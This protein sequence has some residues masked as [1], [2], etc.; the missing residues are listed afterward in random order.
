MCREVKRIDNAKFGYYM[1]FEFAF[2]IGTQRQSEAGGRQHY[3]GTSLGGRQH[4]SRT[5]L[6]GERAG[7][8]HGYLAAW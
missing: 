3:S 2:E 6:G 5:S 8:V 4:Y 1:T 7:G